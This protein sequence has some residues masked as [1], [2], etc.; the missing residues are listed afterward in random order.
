M[1]VTVQ[2]SAALRSVA[3]GRDRIEIGSDPATV[4]DALEALWVLCP[5]LRDRIVT[6]EAEIREHVNVFVGPENVRYTGGLATPL[7]A[8]AELSIF[9]A[10]SGGA[11]LNA[12]CGMR[13]V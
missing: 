8:G 12:E 1:S 6:E 9:Q 11:G 10:V 7:T 3:G 13:T 5:G 2:I 4:G